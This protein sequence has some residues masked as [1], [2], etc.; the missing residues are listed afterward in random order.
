MT[1][2]V[3]LIS[4]TGETYYGSGPDNEGLRYKTENLQ[5]AEKFETK[6]A[7][8][9][10]FYWFKQMREISDYEYEAVEL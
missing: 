3:K 4:P 9:E 2:V 10:V 8:E 1:F 7:A 6:K 5:N